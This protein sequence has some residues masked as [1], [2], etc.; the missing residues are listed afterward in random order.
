MREKEEDYG[1]IRKNENSRTFLSFVVIDINNA[2][3]SLIT[4]LCFTKGARMVLVL[5]R[6]SFVTSPMIVEIIPMKLHA[7]TTWHAAT[8]KRTS[9]LGKNKLMMNWTGPEGKDQRHLCRL[10]LRGII[11]WELWQVRVLSDLAQN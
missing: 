2:L 8:L 10:A 6:I 1:K 7:V 9:A 4:F 3:V 11:L 5:R